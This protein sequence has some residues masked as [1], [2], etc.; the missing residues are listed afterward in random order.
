MELPEQLRRSLTWDQAAE[1]AQHVQL[2]LNT[3]LA[4]HFCVRIALG[5]AAPTR[6]PTGCCASTSPRAPTS[7]SR[8]SATWP[9]SPL[10]GRPRKGPRLADPA[11]ALNDLYAQLSKPALRRLIEPEQYTS[12]AFG[13]RLRTAG[14]LGSI[15]T[16]GDAYDNAMAD[17]FLSTL[18]REL[19]NQHRWENRRQL[20]LAVFE[21]IAAWCNPRRRHSSIGDLSRI[22]YEGRFTPAAAAA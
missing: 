10:N 5:G 12:W 15:G 2:R 22:G 6:T 3:G 9:P 17:S 18:Q 7:P 4:I 13:R 16:I 21:W 11:G 1:M 14:V 19:L 8:A 20:A